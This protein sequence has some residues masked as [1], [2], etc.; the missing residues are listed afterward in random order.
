M[1][2]P[3]D[4]SKTPL[5]LP[6]GLP[7]AQRTEVQEE[8]P[9]QPGFDVLEELLLQKQGGLSNVLHLLKVE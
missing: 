4:N 9:G 2:G 6:R 8:T 3:H 7:E 5:S 1:T